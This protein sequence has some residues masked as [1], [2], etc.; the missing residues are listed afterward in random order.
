MEGRGGRKKSC[1]FY[2]ERT[3]SCRRYDSNPRPAIRGRNDLFYFY[4]LAVGSIG[5]YFLCS[6]RVVTAS[7]YL[8]C[9]TK[10][11]LAQEALPKRVAMQRQ[12]RYMSFASG[13]TYG[14]LYIG[15]YRALAKHLSCVRGTNISQF[16][17]SVEGFAGTSIGALVAL[18]FC[19]NLSADKYEAFFERNLRLNELVPNPDFAQMLQS[20]GLDR[21]DAI[22]RMISDILGSAGISDTATFDDL[23]RLLKRDFACVATNLTTSLPQIFSA[24]RTPLVRICDAVYMSMTIPFLFVPYIHDGDTMVDGGL[25]MHMPNVFDADETLFV[26]LRSDG[27]RLPTKTFQDFCVA[28]LTA[29]ETDTWYKKK[30]CLELRTYGE[31]RTHPCDFKIDEH[32]AHRIRCG[33]AATMVF[34]Y[35]KI[36]DALQ[37]ALRFMCEANLGRR[38]QTRAADEAG[39]C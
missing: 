37:T 16:L 11:N 36:A 31:N 4:I 7:I 33:Y 24:Q 27:A 38:L 22:K 17:D 6:T 21:G 18:A 15:F 13:G 5:L 39:M 3:C 26:D 25:T 2:M 10:A 23:K 35:P 32:V 30:W 29:G 34:L 28:C 14:I 9:A 19:L 20:F 1:F 8:P 12:P